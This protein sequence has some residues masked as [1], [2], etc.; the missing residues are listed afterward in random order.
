MG[1]I[2][3]KVQCDNQTLYR[4]SK[5]DTK[6]W[7]GISFVSLLLIGCGGSDS[8]D[9]DSTSDGSTFNLTGAHSYKGYYQECES[10]KAEGTIEFEE[11]YY[12][13]E[14]E[15]WHS[16]CDLTNF[17]DSGSHI[18]ENIES[19]NSSEFDVF[20]RGWYPQDIFQIEYLTFNE[21]GIKAKITD[22]RDDSVEFFELFPVTSDGESSVD[23]INIIGTW[24]YSLTYSECP[25]IASLGSVTW[26]YHSDGYGLSIAR[27]EKLSLSSCSFVDASDLEAEEHYPASNPITPEEFQAGW[28]D[29]DSGVYWQSIEFE[30]ANKIILTGIDDG[31]SS[32]EVIIVFTRD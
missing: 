26:T 9:L 11:S 4:E 1:E 15:D 5:M 12:S 30:S 21:S 25:D 10:D 13:V 32:S 17:T 27:T 8:P 22:L 18:F 28:N 16:D 20:L 19:I 7:L 2:L 23:T 29:L 24:A 14:G 3:R 31:A 6:K